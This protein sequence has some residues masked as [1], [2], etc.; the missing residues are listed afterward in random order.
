EGL[1]RKFVADCADEYVIGSAGVSAYD[2]SP[3]SESTIQA[4]LEEG[5]D[6]SSHRSRRLT[7]RMVEEADRIYVME[8]LHRDL[9]LQVWPGATPKVLLLRE[10]LKNVGSNPNDLD[11]PD[12]IGMSDYFYKNVLLV[13]RDCIEQIA[14]NR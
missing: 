12:P 13:I 5:L 3:A 7:A 4:L 11:I 9:I 1:F 10:V 14:A 6:A 2:G 8:R